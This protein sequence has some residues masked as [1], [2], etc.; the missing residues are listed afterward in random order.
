MSPSSTRYKKF[1]AT[2]FGYSI[3]E[4][5]RPG[6][7]VTASGHYIER[8]EDSYVFFWTDLISKKH[9]LAISEINLSELQY[10]LSSSDV[11]M[12]D[13]QTIRTAP[14][15]KDLTLTY[16]DIDFG[17]ADRAD[18][19][20]VATDGLTIKFLSGTEKSDLEQ[21]YADCSEKDQ[22]TLDLT[23]DEEVALGL[24]NQGRLAA[25]SRYAPIRDS[26]IADITVVVRAGERG[27]G[28]STPLVSEIIKLALEQG[29][30][31]K[32]RVDES[33]AASIAIANRLGFKPLSHIL[34]WEVGQAF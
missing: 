5:A 20:A 3:E 32:Y 24:Y 19:R 29:Y 2:M 11:Q 6:F 15:F 16:K 26:G 14:Y 9:I 28:Y 7:S 1:W 22:E 4:M 25:I 17:L 8:H 34:A 30:E 27:L 31:P 10:E 33:N 18:F 13:S 23:F 21:F 12:L